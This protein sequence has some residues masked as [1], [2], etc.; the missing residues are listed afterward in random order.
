MMR[1]PWRTL[2]EGYEDHWMIGPYLQGDEPD[3]YGLAG[4][5]R[6]E[7]LSTGEKVLIDFAAALKNVRL[8]LDAAHQIRVMCALQLVASGI[9][10]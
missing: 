5:D 6:L 10:P 9:Q 3:W 1:E 7:A 4:D 8:H 2:L